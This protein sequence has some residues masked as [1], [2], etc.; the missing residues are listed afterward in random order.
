MA[1]YALNFF[2]ISLMWLGGSGAVGWCRFTL[3]NPS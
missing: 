1:G 2:T 3:S